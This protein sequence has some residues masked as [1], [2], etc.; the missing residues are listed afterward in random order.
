M[1]MTDP[2]G[3]FEGLGG[4]SLSTSIGTTLRGIAVGAAFG[5]VL[6]TA[7]ALLRG[8]DADGALSAAATGGLVGGIGG[9]LVL[10]KFVRP[11]LFVAGGLLGIAGVTD[12]I[13]QENATL[14]A[15]RATLFLV[16][17]IAFFRT[18]PEP[19]VASGRLGNQATRDHIRHVVNVMRERGWKLRAGGGELPEEYLPGPGPGEQRW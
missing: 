19:T 1:R 4:L 10:I 17:S 18:I 13:E 7:D 6:G 16:G 14:A 3:A 8:E 9:S 15:F 12:A 2:T 11:V 5:S